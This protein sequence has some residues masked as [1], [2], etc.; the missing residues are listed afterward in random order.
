MK[1]L[2]G[3]WLKVMKISLK[4]KKEASG[5]VKGTHTSFIMN[6][7]KG[8]FNNFLWQHLSH[9]QYKIPKVDFV[10][11]FMLKNIQNQGWPSNAE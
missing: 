8:H 9:I 7:F 4:K 3:E 10:F 5:K 1:S 2:T 6:D 11:L